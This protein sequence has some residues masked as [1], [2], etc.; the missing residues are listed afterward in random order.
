MR[1][2]PS[3]VSCNPRLTREIRKVRETLEVPHEPRIAIKPEKHAES[4][5][6]AE[7]RAYSYDEFSRSMNVASPVLLRRQTGPA[8]SAPGET[9]DAEA[10]SAGVALCDEQSQSAAHTVAR[11]MSSDS[12]RRKFSI[13]VLRNISRP[14]N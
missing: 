5:N 2:L 8:V 6:E 9:E 4:S 3:P 10:N 12:L 11:M 14:M 7:E 1:N 13:S